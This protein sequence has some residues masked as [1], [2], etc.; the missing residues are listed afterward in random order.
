MDAAQR[1]P[2]PTHP[3]AARAAA[4]PLFDPTK[5]EL[6]HVHRLT[7]EQL[8][9][10]MKVRDLLLALGKSPAERDVIFFPSYTTVQTALE[11]LRHPLLTLGYL[12]LPLNPT[13]L[14][15]V[16]RSWPR[17]ESFLLP[18]GSNSRNVATRRY[19]PSHPSQTCSSLPTECSY[20]GGR[21]RSGRRTLHALWHR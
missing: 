15:R 6:V 13:P 2:H 11:V 4:Q 9:H 18:C 8:F 14:F 17:S 16:I 12:V 7:R 1:Y 5:V 19:G 20:S 3:D 10:D 21:A